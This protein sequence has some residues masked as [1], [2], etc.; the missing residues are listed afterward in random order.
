[1]TEVSMSSGAVRV[2]SASVDHPVDRGLDRLFLKL[3][4][5]LLAHLFQRGGL[6]RACR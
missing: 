4:G 3:L 2:M 6:V 5:D 1:M